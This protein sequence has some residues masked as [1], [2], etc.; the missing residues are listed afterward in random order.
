MFGIGS[1]L[2]CRSFVSPGGGAFKRCRPSSMPIP[3]SDQN[4]TSLTTMT[5]TLPLATKQSFLQGRGETA[6][7]RFSLPSYYYHAGGRR[8]CPDLLYQCQSFDDFPQES[9]P[10]CFL[11]G[12]RKNNEML[13]T[14]S[15]PA[16]SLIPGV[17]GGG[18]S[19]EP[20]IYFTQA[21]LLQNSMVLPSRGVR[22]F[23]TSSC[24]SK[25]EEDVAEQQWMRSTNHE[26]EGNRRPFDWEGPERHDDEGRGDIVRVEEHE[27]YKGDRNRSVA[28]VGCRDGAA[29]AQER[30]RLRYSQS[31]VKLFVV[32]KDVSGR[33]TSSFSSSSSDAVVST[34]VG[35][36]SPRTIHSSSL[37]EMRWSPSYPFSG[38]LTRDLK[39]T[40]G[41]DGS[42]PSKG[43]FH[44]RSYSAQVLAAPSECVPTKRMMELQWTS[45]QLG[46][47]RRSSESHSHHGHRHLEERKEE[48]KS[49]RHEGVAL[50]DDFN[51]KMNCDGDAGEVADAR[52]LR[53]EEEE[54]EHARK[55]GPQMLSRVSSVPAALCMVCEED[56]TVISQGFY[57]DET[58]S[59]PDRG[60]CA[61]VDSVDTPRVVGGDVLSHVEED[62]VRGDVPAIEEGHLI[63]SGIEDHSSLSSEIKE[64]TC[65][66][67]PLP[68]EGDPAAEGLFPS[69]PAPYLAQ[70]LQ[71]DDIY[72]VA[73]LAVQILPVR[74]LQRI[75]QLDALRTVVGP[76]L[77]VQCTYLATVREI[78]E[79]SYEIANSGSDEALVQL[80][81]EGLV[82]RRQ[83]AREEEEEEWYSDGSYTRE[84]EGR[85][86]GGIKTK[87]ES[88]DKIPE[89]DLA[90]ECSGGNSHTLA[91]LA[92]KLKTVKM[93][94]ARVGPNLVAGIVQLAEVLMRQ[95]AAAFTEEK[96]N[97]GAR[98]I[99]LS[100]KE[101]RRKDEEDS[102][103][104]EEL[105]RKEVGKQRAS[106]RDTAEDGR[107]EVKAMKQEKIQSFVDHFLHAFLSCRVAAEL[108][109]EHFLQSVDGDD[110]GAILNKHI[111]ME[112]LVCQAALD[113]QELS[114]H[115]MGTAAPVEV[116][117]SEAS[118]IDEDL[119][120]FLDKASHTER[121]SSVGWSP[122]SYPVREEV[123]SS[124]SLGHACSSSSGGPSSPVLIPY[125]KS[126]GADVVLSMEAMPGISSNRIKV[127][128]LTTTGCQSQQGG[129]LR[130]AGGG[131]S[132]SNRENSRYMS[133]SFFSSSRS[134]GGGTSKVDSRNLNDS[135]RTHPGESSCHSS[136]STPLPMTV[137]FPCFISY[138]YSG[139]FE[140]LKNAMRASVERWH[141]ERARRRHLLQQNTRGA[142]RGKD[143]DDA[144]GVAPLLSS[145]DE[146]KKQKQNQLHDMTSFNDD[147]HD[148]RFHDDTT[149]H[150]S[151]GRRP[152]IGLGVETPHF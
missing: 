47:R 118:S 121:P 58:A 109:R 68:G 42:S 8:S 152:D 85:G 144:D 57:S 139:V 102:D 147:H 46:F 6:A 49:L 105:T 73:E 106:F 86:K 128:C 27:G 88:H 93:L 80:K 98:E 134:G 133:S 101:K 59:S 29:I 14:G 91:S 75:Q 13:S 17:S 30:E 126:G 72:E 112:Q 116:Y 122:F 77:Y 23:C 82:Y 66:I 1:Y 54:E 41:Q 110:C 5:T 74:Y 125:P 7:A 11:K 48:K 35:C 44:R 119:R 138:A 146:T 71:L 124:S 2:R 67:Q 55:D 145:N 107:D 87:V 25:E 45:G 84:Q 33:E 64:D 117:C 34:R 78:Y 95:S 50:I 79:K 76:E 56:G 62:G 26:S 51:N 37:C 149:S 38:L 36:H 20:F 39:E 3:C 99:S 127:N 123:N 40:H 114:L 70:L 115:H 96:N 150:T 16:P 22:S 136:S 52:D 113:A 140:L 83:K 15:V 21:Q 120:V 130:G 4:T 137:R 129:G 69:P 43:L 10:G 65:I 103:E 28:S 135:G 148:N 141:E 92:E 142:N 89:D 32:N 104:E 100:P 111:P 63:A 81:R 9:C 151:G 24:T 19:D 94:Q 53:K 143:D 18:G 61:G 90:S 31:T 131:G 97:S 132:L 108:Q 12:K 60:I